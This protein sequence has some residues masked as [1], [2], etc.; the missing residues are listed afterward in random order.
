MAENDV[1]QRSEHGIANG[2]AKAAAFV[3]VAVRVFVRHR[4]AYF[5]NPGSHSD[6][7]GTYVTS[8]SARHIAP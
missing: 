2:A 4:P 7:A 5:I 8:R 1:A 6:S 3:P